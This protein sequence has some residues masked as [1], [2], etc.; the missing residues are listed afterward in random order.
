MHRLIVGNG[1]TPD[2]MVPVWQGLQPYNVAAQ[3]PHSGTA[4]GSVS[5]ASNAQGSGQVMVTIS[6]PWTTTVLCRSS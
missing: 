3:G 6:G 4:T 5:E 2:W 1:P